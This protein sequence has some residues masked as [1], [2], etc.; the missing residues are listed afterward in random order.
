MS[1]LSYQAAIGLRRKCNLR[2]AG[3]GQRIGEPGEQ[4]EQDRQD[5]GGAKMS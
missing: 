4:G 1:P 3:D 2:D 5:D